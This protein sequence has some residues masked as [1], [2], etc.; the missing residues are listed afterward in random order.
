MEQYQYKSNKSQI[1]SLKVKIIA[2]TLIR[3]IYIRARKLYDN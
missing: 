3:N 1:H 2:V